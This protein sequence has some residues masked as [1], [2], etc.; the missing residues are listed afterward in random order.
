MKKEIQ[1]HSK[2]LE[3]TLERLIA[4]LFSEDESRLILLESDHVLEN[5]SRKRAWIKFSQLVIP[6]VT[7]KEMVLAHLLWLQSIG[8]VVIYDVDPLYGAVLIR[9]N[10]ENLES[11]PQKS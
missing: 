6:G 1:K 5:F 8:R 10:L 4:V 11:E 2:H 3:V 7:D 9:L